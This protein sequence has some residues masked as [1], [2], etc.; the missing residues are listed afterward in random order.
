MKPS[1]VF[2]SV[3]LC[4]L[5]STGAFAAAPRKGDFKPFTDSLIVWMEQRTTVVQK[6][7]L[8][9]CTV[10]G[11]TVDLYFNAELS[12]YPWRE[13]DVKWLRSEAGG[14]IKSLDSG[15]SLGSI[16]SNR[17]ELSQLALPRIG[18]S[19]QFNSSWKQ[20]IEDPHKDE[21]HPLVQAEGS[22]SYPKG[23]SNRY[24]ALWQSHGL[25]Y[26]AKEDQWQW[27][28]APLH[29]TVEDMFTQ[30]FVLDFL[31]PML[32]RAGAYLVMPR[33]RDIQTEEV[34]CDNDP[35]FEGERD[36]K[37]RRKGE[38]SR[39]GEWSSEK[40]GFADYKRTYTFADQPFGAGT[41]LKAACSSKGGSRAVWKPSF[42]KR[43]EY[44]VYV[45]YTSYLNSSESAQYTVRHLGGETKLKVNQKMGGGTWIYLGTFEFSPG[46]EAYVELTN[47]GQEGDVV[48]ADAVK[49]GGGYGK[50][51]RGGSISG[52]ASS[53]EGAHYNMHLSGADST[54]TQNWD[55][56]YTNDFASRGIWTAMMKEQKGIPIDLSLAFHT[57]AGVAKADSTIGTLAIYTLRCDGE[58]E[59]SDGRDRL[60][61][62][63]L[64]DYVQTQ[65]VQDLRADYKADWNRRGI[66]DKSYSECR[67]TSVPAMILELL[68]HQNFGDMKYGLD[69]AFRFSTARA[70][71][72]GILKTLADYYQR[73]YQVAPLPVEALQCSLLPGSRARVEWQGRLDGKEPT[74]TNE[75]YIV[76]VRKDDGAFD[77]GRRCKDNSFEM[78]I[79]PGHIYSFM[80]EAFNQGGRSFPSEV[81]SLCSMGAESKGEVLIVNNFTRVS[82]PSW[83][84]GE[85]Y[86]G[87]DSRQDS[88]VGYIRE[89][90]YIGENYDFD[91]NSEFIDNNS[92][93]F[94]ASY[95]DM[96]GSIIAGNTFDFAYVHGKAFAALGYSFASC[97]Q[98]AFC[99]EG[100]S[101]RKAD[102]VDLICG[103][104]GGEKYPVFPEEMKKALKAQCAQGTNILVSGS[105][106]ASDVS[107]LQDEFTSKALGFSLIRAYG[108]PGAQI[109]PHMYSHHLNQ[110]I[111]CVEHPDALKAS[112]FSRSSKVVLRYPD[113]KLPGAVVSNMGKYRCAAI[114]VPLETLLNDNDRISVLN[115]VLDNMQGD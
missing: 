66:W 69:P 75:G 82:A 109:G 14:F 41:S 28:R 105:A 77:G 3:V 51:E 20:G 55:N 27:Q 7:E 83:I 100:T 67:T 74:A 37:T 53:A 43:G 1:T 34:I 38:F 47:R 88:G 91:P 59:I 36:L 80:V 76:Y 102:I 16:Y 61:S 60:I 89:I 72:K 94:G 71:Y 79:E 31:A 44:A 42:S 19:G 101:E 95:S 92:P 104:Q 115:M 106:I 4:L 49:F 81:V 86:A 23:L 85:S 57:D 9:R 108:T 84:D 40:G 6:P 48:S 65:I 24:I 111:Y 73:P 58:R 17:Y 107:A 15:Y 114:G 25:Y 90:G 2:A 21:K 11:K 110:S 5:F 96:A 62:R 12:Y 50:M 46:Q 64:C 33:E 18:N 45:A 22:S 10:H 87:F 29:R 32:E 103:K 63:L 13:E 39:S 52:M 26:D 30:T 35:G 78:D 98:Q 68:S 99:S 70:V 113:S 54:I 112:S 56:D 8:T 93:G 97:S